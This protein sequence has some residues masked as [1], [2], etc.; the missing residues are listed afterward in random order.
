MLF[1]GDWTEQKLEAISKYLQAYATAL[2][3]TKF[4]R[5]YVDAF[6]G[7][8]YRE[9]R[10]KPDDGSIF[11]QEWMSLEGEESTG[12]LDGSAKRALRVSPPFDQYV[13]IERT[14]RKAIELARL[15]EEF[16]DLADRIS[17]HCADA[18]TTIRQLC[19]RWDKAGSRGVFF[20]DPFGMQ[21]EWD[22]IQAVAKTGCIDTWILFPFAA[23]RLLTK[24]PSDIPNAWRLRLNR[25]FGT[26]EWEQ[27]F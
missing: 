14:A 18:N 16:K 23:N 10:Q 13:F 2:S 20:L 22:T 4:K 27:R 25:F 11:D 7:T 8:G 26:D 1:G 24:F 3:K 17:V 19:S 5:I 6:A 12:F 9:L 21:A 15:T